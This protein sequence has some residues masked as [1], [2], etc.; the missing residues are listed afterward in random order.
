M[1]YNP[2][3]HHRK[4]IRLKGFGYSNEGMY[5]ITI[6]TYNKEFIFYDLV[7]AG[8]PRPL[9]CLNKYGEVVQEYWDNIS[10]HFKGVE[11]DEFVIMP[12]H[13]H[14]IIKINPY[15]NQGGETPPLQGK[16]PTLGQ[17]VGY[18]KYQTTKTINQID[19]TPGRRVWQRNY[20][21]QIIRTELDYFKI[22]QYIKDNP[23]NWYSDTENPCRSGVSPPCK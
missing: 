19:T 20:Y 21:E 16:T 9:P 14:G 4:S 17:I 2:D 7:G 13:I 15:T 11:I 12:N 1:T 10:N 5:F 3:I 6:C 8:F 22:T 23:G 18:F